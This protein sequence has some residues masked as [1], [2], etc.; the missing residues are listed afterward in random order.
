[1]SKVPKSLSYQRCPLNQIYNTVIE[2]VNRKVI[3]NVRGIHNFDGEK[4]DYYLV[5]SPG[6][7]EMVTYFVLGRKISRV[8]RT[9]RGSGA[10][11]NSLAEVV[12][13]MVRARRRRTLK[14]NA[15][16]VFSLSLSL[17][18]LKTRRVLKK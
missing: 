18:F 5:Y 12:Y 14:R 6:K 16:I 11:N 17:G 15:N 7:G 10:T 9:G 8:W 4:C 2:N 3:F 13:G 1:M